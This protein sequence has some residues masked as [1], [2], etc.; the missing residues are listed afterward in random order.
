MARLTATG[1]A[2][3]PQVTES[4][5]QTTIQA[6]GFSAEFVNANVEREG[7]VLTLTLGEKPGR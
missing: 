2:K 3:E 1:L 6:E 7:R 5:G 4:E